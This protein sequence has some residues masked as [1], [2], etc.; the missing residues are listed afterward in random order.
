M[1]I[2]EINLSIFVELLHTL[3]ELDEAGG[4]KACSLML[5]VK[6]NSNKKRSMPI[7]IMCQHV[8][9]LTIH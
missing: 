4:M 3:T 7:F 1:L 9:L 8:F 6:N 2:L 5:L